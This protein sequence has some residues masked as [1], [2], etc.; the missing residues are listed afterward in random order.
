MKPRGQEHS[1]NYEIMES[2]CLRLQCPSTVQDKGQPSGA[3][4]EALAFRTL[5]NFG[6]EHVISRLLTRKSG[7]NWAIMSSWIGEVK[8]ARER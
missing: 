2:D 1:T 6:H 7:K 3:E 8:G 4:Q 5:G